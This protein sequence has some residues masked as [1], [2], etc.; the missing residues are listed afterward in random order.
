MYRELDHTA[1]VQFE[2]V[3]ES[4]N[5]VFLDLIEIF[6]THYEP[7]FLSYCVEIEYSINKSL[8][9]L[10]FDTV[11]DWIYL[12]DAKGL[13]PTDCVVDGQTLRV[14]FCAFRS[15]RGTEFKA[16]TYHGL[17]ISVDENVLKLKVV[18]DT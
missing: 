3:C 6:K 16:L 13:F 1:D 11:N 7:I 12:I 15:L 5:C 14:R 8:E 9:D 18:F 10:V 17:R 2:I 4:I